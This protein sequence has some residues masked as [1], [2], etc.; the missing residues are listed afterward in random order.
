MLENHREIVPDD[1]LVELFLVLRRYTWR[2]VIA[3]H[4][5]NRDVVARRNEVGHV[6]EF[7]I[8][9]VKKPRRV[10]VR[11]AELNHIIS[12]AKDFTFLAIHPVNAAFFLS[13]FDERFK[14]LRVEGTGV[15]CRRIQG[16]FEMLFMH[17]KGRLRKKNFMILVTRA[18]STHVV[19]MEVAHDEIRNVFWFQVEVFPE[20]FD[21][22]IFLTLHAETVI[23]LVTVVIADT[24]INE[25]I[26]LVRLDQH[27]TETHE[28]A[29]LFVRRDRF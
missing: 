20:S 8:V 4:P 1:E 14:V 25:N 27:D 26:P 18:E 19:K 13:G 16:I 3:H 21:E 2:N 7:F 29:V 22:R 6:N 15:T 28:N 12:I 17:M 23:E 11:A 9:R 24:G 10:S 5:R